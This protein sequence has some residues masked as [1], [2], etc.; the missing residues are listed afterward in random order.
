MGY[1]VCLQESVLSLKFPKKI[2]V[3]HCVFNSVFKTDPR[4]VQRT[5]SVIIVQI[6]STIEVLIFCIA[7]G[8]VLLLFLSL[9]DLMLAPTLHVFRFKFEFYPVTALCLC[10]GPVEAHKNMLWGLEKR[11]C[12]PSNTCF[13]RHKHVPTSHQNYHPLVTTNTD[14]NCP[15][16][17]HL[18]TLKR[19]PLA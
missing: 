4:R 13:S 11:L 10:S 14:G 1:V 5:I 12:F 2:H 3:I 7:R 8:P 6:P 16:V 17:S 18:Q 15:E 9:L 19:S